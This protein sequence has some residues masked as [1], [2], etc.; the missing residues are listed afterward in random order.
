[1]NLVT[2]IATQFLITKT[3]LIQLL[4]TFDVPAE[5]LDEFRQDRISIDEDFI[6]RKIR[7]ICQANQDQT[8]QDLFCHEDGIQ[9][10]FHINFHDSHFIRFRISFDIKIIDCILTNHQQTIQLMINN[11]QMKSLNRLSKPFRFCL[12]SKIRSL[13]IDELERICKELNVPFE[14]LFT[15]IKRSLTYEINLSNIKEFHVLREKYFLIGNQ[16]ILD[17]IQITYVEHREQAIVLGYRLHSTINNNEST[18]QF[19]D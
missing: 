8:F 16:T 14:R 7:F 3:T 5:F 9:F 1:M 18:I 6:R 4:K 19:N 17:L 12:K 13:V 2:Q 15:H 11:I 10:V